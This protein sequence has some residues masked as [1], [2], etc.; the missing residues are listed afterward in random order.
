MCVYIMYMQY[1]RVC[2]CV[3]EQYMLIHEV[4]LEWVRWGNSEIPVCQL[5][6]TPADS[7]YSH[8]DKREEEE[9]ESVGIMLKKLFQVS[10]HNVCIGASY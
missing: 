1:I 4:V 6:T 2:T 5:T 3:Q 7:W 10:H 8:R 9:E